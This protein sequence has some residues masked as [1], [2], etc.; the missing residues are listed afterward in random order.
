MASEVSWIGQA[1]ASEQAA[2]AG[3]RYS[4]AR[5]SGPQVGTRCA[6]GE[7]ELGPGAPRAEPSR[8][9][10]TDGSGRRKIGGH[11]RAAGSHEWGRGAA[12]S[13]RRAETSST[14]RF[15]GWCLANRCRQTDSCVGAACSSHRRSGPTGN[16][17][18]RG[19]RA[20]ES[21]SAAEAPQVAGISGVDGIHIH[22]AV[23]ACWR[24]GSRA[25]QAA[26]E[27]D[28][29]VQSA[30]N[31]CQPRGSGQDAG[32][33]GQPN[34]RGEVGSATQ[35]EEAQ[36][37]EEPTWR[38]QGRWQAPARSGDC[39][40]PGH[41]RRAAAS[42]ATSQGGSRPGARSSR[43]GAWNHYQGASGSPGRTSQIGLIIRPER[44]FMIGATLAGTR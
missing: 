10:R 2:G 26:E 24:E 30:R 39:C 5:N 27:P 20:L 41:H 17:R 44:S 40:P 32:G 12:S 43:E 29:V 19:H 1:S 3:G 7:D 22:E 42:R 37:N 4:S 34:R 28:H 13:T 25:T 15:S 11:L 8:L 6:D 21:S 14:G 33:R 16:L 23:T 18:G 36:T 38:D 35:G 9:F 31:R